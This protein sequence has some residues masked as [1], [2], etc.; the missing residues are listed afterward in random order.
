MNISP[1]KLGHKIRTIC[2]PQVRVPSHGT[3]FIKFG[4]LNLGHAHTHKHHALKHVCPQKPNSFLVGKESR[5]KCNFCS[6]CRNRVYFLHATLTEPKE[7]KKMFF[8]NISCSKWYRSFAHF[9]L[10]LTH[11]CIKELNTTGITCQD[12]R[13]SLQT[14]KNKLNFCGNYST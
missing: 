6:L 8:S 3:I 13:V 14:F 4:Q 5:L 11:K 7:G 12:L 9:K 2:C 1:T 10:Q